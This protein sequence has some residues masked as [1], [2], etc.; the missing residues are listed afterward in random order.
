MDIL[1]ILEAAELPRTSVPICLKGPL[2]AEYEQLDAQLQAVAPAASLAG[3]G[4]AALVA[5]MDDLRAQMLQFEATFTFEALPSRQFSDLRAGIPEKKEGQPDDEWRDLYHEW[6]CLLV[7]T[8]C[9]EPTM[10]PEQVDQLSVKLSDAQWSQLSNAAW[11]IN[12][13]RQ[14]IPFSNA[15][16]VLS[17]NS[18]AKSRRQEQPEPPE[19][20]SLAGNPDP[21]P[22]TST[23]TES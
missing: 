4:S 14:D 10:T 18:G 22:S 6:V 1:S 17:L 11:R 12:A 21:S 5:R 9:V 13:N 23:Q 19:V 2:V 15:A 8:C 7:A 3:D 16:F 20:D